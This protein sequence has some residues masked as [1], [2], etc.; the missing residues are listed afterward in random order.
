[1]DDEERALV[2]PGMWSPE[3]KEFLGRMIW[4][5]KDSEQPVD[6]IEMALF[7]F[8]RANPALRLI[9]TDGKV[10]TEWA[11]LL[12]SLPLGYVR[13]TG[14]RLEIDASVQANAAWQR[15]GSSR[16]GYQLWATFLIELYEEMRIGAA[17]ISRPEREGGPEHRAGKRGKPPQVP[18][19]TTLAKWTATWRY[20]RP[21]V[22]RGLTNPRDLLGML[23]RDEKTAHL[24]H[25]SEDTMRKI[26][27]AG[28]AGRLTADNS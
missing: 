24:A 22:E 11:L 16:E 18:K 2:I 13:V 27:A 5:C 25:Q 4:R 28:L 14:K 9:R 19:G 17:L 10:V 12:G 20:V 21:Y 15:H 26:V 6:S 23:A 7:R 3:R 1:M 8:Q